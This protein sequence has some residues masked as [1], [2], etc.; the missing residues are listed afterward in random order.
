MTLRPDRVAV[1]SFAY[2]PWMKAHMKHLPQASCRAPSSSSSCSALAIEAFLGAGYAQIGMDHFA[3]PEDELARARRAP[4]TLHRNF[5]GYTVQSARDMVA[6]G[7]SGIGDV[8]GAFVQNAKKLPE[9]YGA[10]DAGRFP[11]ERGYALDRR[12]PD[13]P[14]R[15]HDADVQRPSRHR[16]TSSAVRDRVRRVLRGGARGADRAGV[17]AADGLVA[18]D[19]DAIEVTP[20]GRLF[21]RNVCMMFDR[22]LRAR[23]RRRRSRCSAARYERRPASSSS[24]PGSPGW[25]CGFTLRAGGAAAGRALDRRR[26]RGSRVRRRPRADA[27]T[28]TASWSRRGRTA[29]SIASR[30]TLALVE[31]SDLSRASIEARPRRQAALHRP[32]R[33]PVRSARLAARR[34]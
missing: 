27:R 34:C 11:I 28:R 19:A 12:R 25:R 9:Y 15:D 8:Q 32:R 6:L 7:V 26:A 20:L 5:M 18:I 22:Y 31:R 17:A 10:I 33:P 4:R 3:L 14:P 24:A 30:E 21:V 16:A 1:Y 23:T 13:P 2:V 29:S